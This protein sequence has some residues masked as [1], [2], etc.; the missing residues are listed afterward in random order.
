MDCHETNKGWGW[1]NF[2]GSITVITADKHEVSCF[3]R[4][5]CSNTS[6]TIKSYHLLTHL[7]VVESQSRWWLWWEE[8]YPMEGRGGH[9]QMINTWFGPI[10][11]WTW[12][13]IQRHWLPKSGVSRIFFYWDSITL[14]ALSAQAP[15]YQWLKNSLETTQNARN[16]FQA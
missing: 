1:C 12:T 5:Y 16:Y 2:T 7:Q 13:L 8:R 11:M 10:Y 3:V 14:E 4:D 6:A 15:L 9:N